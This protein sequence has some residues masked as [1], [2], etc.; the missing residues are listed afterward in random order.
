MDKQQKKKKKAKDN[1]SSKSF[2]C[3][4]DTK[5][6]ATSALMLGW[7]QAWKKPLWRMLL[8]VCVSVCVHLCVCVRTMTVDYRIELTLG[9]SI[10]LKVHTVMHSHIHTQRNTHTHIYSIH[11]VCSQQY[12][13]FVF[14]SCRPPLP[15]FISLWGKTRHPA[16][17]DIDLDFVSAIW[18][19]KVQPRK[20]TPTFSKS[21]TSA[22]AATLILSLC[23]FILEHPLW[24]DSPQSSGRMVDEGITCVFRKPNVT[25]RQR[26]PGLL[27]ASD[28]PVMKELAQRFFFFSP[29]PSLNIFIADLKLW[30]F[31]FRL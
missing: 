15:L 18:H 19:F 31:Q 23:A 30:Y 28:P 9:N 26:E 16:A 29:P 22:D 14:L 21:I 11:T 27:K 2:L 25:L 7:Q 4:I 6:L 13:L 8:C 1:I 24:N 10:T 20:K 5:L 12:I 17:Q 3:S